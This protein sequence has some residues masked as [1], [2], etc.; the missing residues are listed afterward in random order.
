MKKGISLPMQFIVMA[1]LAL[2][3]LVV[4][5]VFMLQGQSQIDVIGAAE[6]VNLCDSACFQDQT[7]GRGISI[8]GSCLYGSDLRFLQKKFVIKGEGEQSC[9]DLTSCKLNTPTG[10]CMINDFTLLDPSSNIVEICTEVCLMDGGHVIGYTTLPN[11]GTIGAKGLCLLYTKKGIDCDT[12]NPLPSGNNVN[13]CI[14]SSKR[15]S[16]SAC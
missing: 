8:S 16:S 6:A 10:D 11:I 13:A 3:V 12:Y 7:A 15:F 4:V 5:L 9:L 2:I 1:A 14:L